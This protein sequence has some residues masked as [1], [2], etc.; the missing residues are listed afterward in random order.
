[1]T[2]DASNAAAPIRAVPDLRLGMG[3]SSAAANT[4]KIGNAESNR[5][6]AAP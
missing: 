5:P 2:S 3:V 6:S 1:M 4:A